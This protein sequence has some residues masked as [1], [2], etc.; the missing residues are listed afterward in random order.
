MRKM[1]DVVRIDSTPTGTNVR[2]VKKRVFLPA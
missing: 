2:L 1:M